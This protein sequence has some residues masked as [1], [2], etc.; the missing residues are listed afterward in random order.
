[1]GLLV[2]LLGFVGWLCGLVIFRLG[3]VGGLS[4]LK[5]LLVS[6][7]LLLAGVLKLRGRRLDFVGWL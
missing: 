3:V 6:L 4:G 2:G 5:L 7:Q 1:M